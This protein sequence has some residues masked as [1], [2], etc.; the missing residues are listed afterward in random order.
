MTLNK[1]L[2][3]GGLSS[4]VFHKLVRLGKICLLDRAS[5]LFPVK[6]YQRVVEGQVFAI[7]QSL[8]FV[9][10]DA[11]YRSAV[12]IGVFEPSIL[13]SRSS[14]NSPSSSSPL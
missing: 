6:P 9:V 14:F 13:S 4:S 7:P 11:P 5:A 12:N 3:R 2:L 8:P 1:F 10:D